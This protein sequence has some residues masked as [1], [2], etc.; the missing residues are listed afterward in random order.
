VFKVK[1]KADGSVDKY[2]A[3]LV[4]QGFTQRY[5]IDY[6]DTF[7]PVVKPATVRLVLA[8]AVSRHWSVR[9]LDISNAFLHGTLEETAYM[10]QPPGF[11]DSVNPHY[12]CKLHKSIYGLSPLAPGTLG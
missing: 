9:Q 11:E 12:V 6:L 3:G 4:A 10:R 7:S 8:L 1:H 2:K 5:G